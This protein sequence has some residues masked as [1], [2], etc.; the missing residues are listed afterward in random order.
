MQ[1]AIALSRLISTGRPLPKIA[2][3]AT[4]AGATVT[5]TATTDIPAKAARLWS[6]L[7]NSA[8]LDTWK[9]QPATPDAGQPAGRSFSGTFD[10]SSGDRAAGYL[11][12][13]YEVDG[14]PYSLTTGAYIAGGSRP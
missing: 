4:E 2:L 3:K 10:R 13:D 6:R 8:S 12:L 14:H 5:L 7:A 11:E 9:D 1:A